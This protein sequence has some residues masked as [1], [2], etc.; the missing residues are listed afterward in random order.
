MKEYGKYLPVS[1]M[2]YDARSGGDRNHHTKGMRTMDWAKANRAWG[3][4]SLKLVEG[5]FSEV[6]GAEFLERRGKL[7][8]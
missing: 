6:S 2:T 1:D 5:T 4:Y 8:C 3:R 7:H